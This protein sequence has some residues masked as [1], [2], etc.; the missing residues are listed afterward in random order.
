MV[1]LKVFL[2]KRGGRREAGRPKLRLV[3]CIENDLTL[4]GVKRLRKKAEDRSA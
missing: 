2:G 4:M 3:T 1:G